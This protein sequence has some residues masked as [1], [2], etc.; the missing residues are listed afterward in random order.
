MWNIVY[1]VIWAAF[2]IFMIR[3][4]I[5]TTISTNK[6]KKEIKEI[7][8]ETMKF[9]PHMSVEEVLKIKRDAAARGC[10]YPEEEE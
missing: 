8:R 2:M 4:I 1:W 10:P 9:F 7:Q 3:S 6:I 5:R